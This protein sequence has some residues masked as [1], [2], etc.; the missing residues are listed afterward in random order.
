MGRLYRGGHA[1]TGK[2]RYVVWLEILKMLEGIASEFADAPKR[3]VGLFEDIERFVDGFIADGVNADGIAFFGSLHNEVVHGRE[4]DGGLPT[5]TFEV[6]ISVGGVQVGGMLA[7]NAVE[8][9]LEAA[10]VQERA[11]VGFAHASKR[12][13]SSSRVGKQVYA[14]SKIAPLLRAS[15]TRRRARSPVQAAPSSSRRKRS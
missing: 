12:P 13:M 6:R 4:R 5:V 1:E 15:H 9:L 8:E 10:D 11:A 3:F 7:G 14:R 2:S